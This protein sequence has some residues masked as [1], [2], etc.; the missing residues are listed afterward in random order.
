MGFKR[1]EEASGGSGCV[2]VLDCG[3]CFMGADICQ[4]HQSIHIKNRQFIVYALY[5]KAKK[6]KTY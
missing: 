4:T 3:N 2:Y 5:L 6:L 1:L